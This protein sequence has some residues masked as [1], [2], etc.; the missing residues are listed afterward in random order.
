[1]KACSLPRKSWAL[2]EG[3]KS[4][5]APSHGTEPRSEPPPNPPPNV[6]GAAP[7]LVGVRIPDGDLMPARRRRYSGGY[8]RRRRSRSRG[9]A[10]VLLLLVLAGATAWYLHR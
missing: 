2:S 4:M 5:A 3:A 6:V 7:T 1:M 10:V 9:S 8:S